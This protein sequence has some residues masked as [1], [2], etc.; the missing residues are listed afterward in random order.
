MS[1]KMFRWVAAKKCLGTTAISDGDL[2]VMRKFKSL[3][4]YTQLTKVAIYTF[5]HTF[6]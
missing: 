1:S 4:K 2:R 6:D 3:H 5:V